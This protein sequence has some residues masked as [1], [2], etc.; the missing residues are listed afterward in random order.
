MDTFMQYFDVG[1]QAPLRNVCKDW[2]N[3]GEPIKCGDVRKGSHMLPTFQALDK[4]NDIIANTERPIFC[5]SDGDHTAEVLN[6]T[7]ALTVIVAL[8][9][10]VYRRTVEKMNDAHA[11][12]AIHL[13]CLDDYTIIELLVG[14]FVEVRVRSHDQFMCSVDTHTFT[15]PKSDITTLIIRS[16]GVDTTVALEPE[17]WGGI[18]GL[19]G[20][21][22]FTRFS[23]CVLHGGKF[24][25]LK[26]LTIF[27]HGKHEDALKVSYEAPGSDD[28]AIAGM[29]IWHGIQ[30]VKT[31]APITSPSSVVS[32][33]WATTPSPTTS[34]SSSSNP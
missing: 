24:R 21:D 7:Q 11:D 12:L 13:E 10:N 1:D 5:N 30:I 23:E 8:L 27:G 2:V 17:F 18:F 31:G 19:L 3:L 9:L 20:G 15:I 4:R 25:T 22:M 33:S 6:I 16:K 14:R 34:P 29:N 32:P 26:S 28:D